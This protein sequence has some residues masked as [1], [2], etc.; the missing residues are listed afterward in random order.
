MDL[1]CALFALLV[2]PTLQ[3]SRAAKRLPRLEIHSDGHARRFPDAMT[4]D[5]YAIAREWDDDVQSIDDVETQ[6]MRV[7]EL[8]EYVLHPMAFST[9]KERVTNLGGWTGWEGPRRSIRIEGMDQGWWVDLYARWCAYRDLLNEALR[10]RA[11][12]LIEWLADTEPAAFWTAA[13][14]AVLAP[15]PPDFDAYLCALLVWP[16]T[17]RRR[18]AACRAALGPHLRHMHAQGVEGRLHQDGAMCLLRTARITLGPRRLDWGEATGPLRILRGRSQEPR[19][20]VGRGRLGHDD[21]R[22]R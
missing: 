11:N 13:W 20:V 9:P 10:Q 1:T 19:L 6:R 14:F 22:R 15:S 3:G 8:I 2:Q 4:I 16:A 21:P 12:D 5:D 7:D 17:R 18:M